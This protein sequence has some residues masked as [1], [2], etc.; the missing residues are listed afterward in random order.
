VTPPD[1]LGAL[2]R[3]FGH[4][5]FRPGQEAAIRAL[6]DGRDLLA[7]YPTGSGKSLVYQLASQALDRATL[8]VSP[9]LAL[10]RDQLEALA[11]R[12][13]PAG[14]VSSAQGQ[15]ANEDAVA[16]VERGE[17]K[18][19]YVTPERFEDDAFVERLRRHVGLLAVVAAH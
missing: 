16:A 15:R 18:L 9:L 13:I 11:E 19:L 10:I 12:G 7:L 6:L 14:A 2:L 17:S 8:V 5:A 1:D 3:R 4:D